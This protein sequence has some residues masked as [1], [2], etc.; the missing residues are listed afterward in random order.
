VGSGEI[1]I[2]NDFEHEVRNIMRENY[3]LVLSTAN[4]KG[5]PHSVVMHASDGNMVY[6]LTGKET[7]KVRNI[8]ENKHVAVTIPFR[9][10]FFTPDDKKNPAG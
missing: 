5:V 7:L 10:N 3:W 9:K 1:N 8:L 4:K 2:M 6:V